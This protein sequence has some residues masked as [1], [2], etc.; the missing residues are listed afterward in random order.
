MNSSL[1][2]LP[3]CAASRFTAAANCSSCRASPGNAPGLSVRASEDVDDDLLVSSAVMDVAV[4]LDV[5][6]DSRALA[7]VATEVVLLILRPDAPRLH[8]ELPSSDAGLSSS[9]LGE[10]CL[11]VAADVDAVAGCCFESTWRRRLRADTILSYMFHVFARR[12]DDKR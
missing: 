3:S 10:D 2:P 5:S 11:D 12:E 9:W 7:V 8:P 6:A 4:E 1:V